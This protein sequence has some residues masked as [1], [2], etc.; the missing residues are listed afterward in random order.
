M[1]FED[2]VKSSFEKVKEEMS[3]LEKQLNELKEEI[4]ALKESL[5]Q[6]IS[7]RNQPMIKPNLYSD[8]SIGNQGVPTN[9]PTAE[10]TFRTPSLPV[11]DIQYKNS[12]TS[13]HFPTDNPTH[14]PHIREK[15]Q[16]INPEESRKANETNLNDL[17]KLLETLKS[18]MKRKFKSLTK[19]EFYIF[20]LL[21]SVDKTQNNTTYQD[22][23][24]RAGLTPSSVRDY[25]Q[26]MIKKGIPVIKEKQN[27]KVI[28]LKLPLELKNLATLDNLMRLREDFPDKNLDTFTKK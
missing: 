26:R 10:P 5:K 3:S 28:V 22:L 14:L 1:S 13:A 15:V 21:Y 25:V 9:Q 20:S 2:K 7:N 23:A 27:N 6:E 19:Q 24:V 18:D 16:Q 4:R 12:R 11:D 8:F 17:S